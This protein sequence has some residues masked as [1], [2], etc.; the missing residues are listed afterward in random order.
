MSEKKEQALNEIQATF[1]EMA[2]LVLHQLTL[3][4]KLMGTRD[5]EL[6]AGLISDM[7]KAESRIDNLEIVIGE[8]FT[9]TIVLY[10][11][12]ASDVRRLVAIYRMS[13]NLERIGD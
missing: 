10:Q 2:N 7:E 6:F 3:M 5:D 12:V 4:E 1:N 8:Q 9:N 13:I 11:P